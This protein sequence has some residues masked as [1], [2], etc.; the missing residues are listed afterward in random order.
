MGCPVVDPNLLG[1]TLNGLRCKD[2]PPSGHEYGTYVP[3]R[4]SARG[5]KKGS[6]NKKDL[7]AHGCP[8]CKERYEDACNES[9]KNFICSFCENGVGWELLREAR[10]PKDCCRAH[11]RLANKDEIKRYSLAGDAKWWICTAC[12]L[13]QI[14]KPK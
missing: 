12:K 14:Y 7:H 2:H 6:A 5:S 8:K 1:L 9:A 4:F 3:N 13:T 10:R 11:S